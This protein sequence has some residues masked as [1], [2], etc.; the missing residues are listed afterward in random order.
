MTIYRVRTVLSFGQ[1]SPGLNT[2]YFVPAGS[3]SSAEALVAVNRVRG[4]WD[5]FKTSL[6]T[7]MTA[8]VS[9][10]VDTLDETTGVLTGSF[11]VATPAVVTGTSGAGQA[12]TFLQAGLLLLTQGIVNGRRV[13]GR[14][15]LGPLHSGNA[16]TALPPASLN[17]NIDA[18]GVALVAS[19]AAPQVVVWSRPIVPPHPNP[20]PGSAFIVSGTTHSAKFWADRSR[21]D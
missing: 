2:H 19:S 17:T 4:C 10:A 1:G 20:R 18:Y 5:V 6:S 8:Q 3:P 7:G 14:S 13:R 11:G 15:N 16:G 12:P 9:G 21:R